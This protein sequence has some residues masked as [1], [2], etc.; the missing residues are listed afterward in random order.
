MAVRAMTKRFR[1]R[2]TKDGDMTQAEQ[3]ARALMHEL[4][5]AQAQDIKYT[6]RE[7]IER[8]K[9]ARGRAFEEDAFRTA[10][11]DVRLGE[12]VDPKL[13]PFPVEPDYYLTLYDGDVDSFMQGQ[14]VQASYVLKTLQVMM[15]QMSLLDEGEFPT[16]EL[17]GLLTTVVDVATEYRDEAMA[18]GSCEEDDAA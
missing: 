11:Q 4:R 10:V 18:R 16:G 9:A 12:Y 2:R 17:V 8:L 6:K 1:P 14:N 5:Q 13:I 15:Q 7:L 3:N